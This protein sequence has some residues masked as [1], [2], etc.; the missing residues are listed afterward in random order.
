MHAAHDPTQELPLAPTLA[1][2]PDEPRRGMRRLAE[3]KFRYVQLSAM[4]PNLRP[5]ELDDG[6]RRDLA[7]TLRRYELIPAGIDV[8]IP[9]LHF[10]DAAHVERAVHAVT[11]TI[12]LAAMLDRC[13]VCLSLPGGTDDDEDHDASTLE[14]AMEA[15][16]DAADH[17]GVVLA[18]H[19]VPPREERM[20]DELIGIGID[21][22]ASL[23]SGGDPV[24]G[25]QRWG[26]SLRAARLVDLTSTGM[27]GP[28]GQPD[29]RLDVRGYK[30]ALSVS[31]FS[32]PVVLDARQW[33]EPWSGMLA[34]AERWHHL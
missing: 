3:A 12:T 4:Q 15:L 34:T 16:R 22:A 1:A 14:Q 2:L 9:P 29:G 26:R 6:A 5:R 27:R 33:H 19:A 13:S 28:I 21:P 10:A 18:D 25:A 30:I 7:A 23:A 24:Q 17:H 32:G 20:N 31:E 8:F 11:E